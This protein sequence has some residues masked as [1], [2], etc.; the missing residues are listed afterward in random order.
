MKSRIGFLLSIIIAVVAC[1]WPELFR[2]RGAVIIL[3]F[4]ITIAIAM[5]QKPKAKISGTDDH[6]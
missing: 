4:A 3:F 1:I 6:K 5:T 2:N